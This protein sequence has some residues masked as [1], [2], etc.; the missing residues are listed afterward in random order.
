[1]FITT[2]ILDL[3]IVRCGKGKYVVAYELDGSDL[4]IQI[5]HY[6]MVISWHS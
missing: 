4:Y 2:R 6:L 5:L 3:S 1:V